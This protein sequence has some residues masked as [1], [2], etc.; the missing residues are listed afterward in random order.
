[1]NLHAASS[2]RSLHSLSWL[3]GFSL[4]IAT[5]TFFLLV[6]GGLVT[7]HKAGLAV[8]DWPLSYGQWFPPMVGNIF[9]EHGHR[10]IAG[11]VGILTLGFSI[12]VQIVEG[13][14]WLKRLAWT[15]FGLVIVQALLG[16]LT[17]LTLLPTVV[18]AAHACAAQTFFCAVAAITYFLSPF[19]PDQAIGDSRLR[20]LAVMTTGWIYLQLV[21]GAMIRHSNVTVIPHVL[22]GLMVALHVLLL[23]SRI[24][25]FYSGEKVLARFSLGL[26]LLTVLQ[27]FSGMGA[28][29]FTRMLTGGYAPPSGEIFFTVLHQTTGALIL[30]VSV[31]VDIRV[32]R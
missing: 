10:M 27:V 24:A 4:L 14:A 9:W 2:Q 16:G 26:G 11:L 28:F 21:L 18:S 31:L 29:I 19:Y 25:R 6:A 7:S 32:W 15:A 23:A 3:Y 8:P 13:R 12:A 1:M 17:V 20:R 30:A 5:A 22:V